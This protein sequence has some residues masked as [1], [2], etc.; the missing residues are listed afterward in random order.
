MSEIVLSFGSFSSSVASNYFSLQTLEDESI[1]FMT[2]YEK[3]HPRVLICDYADC[4]PPTSSSV[5]LRQLQD[6]TDWDGASY[7][8]DRATQ[9]QP[10]DSYNSWTGLSVPLHDKSIVEIPLF[11]G[12]NAA[13]ASY[14]QGGT[15]LSYLYY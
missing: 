11:S 4:T 14:F 8:V 5:D 3:K 12:S 9:L 10:M 6:R 15:D 1:H 2:S 7:I 13:F